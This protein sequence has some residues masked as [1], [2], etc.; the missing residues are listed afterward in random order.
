MVA[1]NSPTMP[2]FPDSEARTAVARKLL[3]I[4]LLLTVV[5]Y[6]GTLRYE[7]V[8]DDDPQIVH[9][10]LLR[11]W[12]SVPRFFTQHLWAQVAPEGKGNFYRPLFLLWFLLN[13]KLFHLQPLGWHVTTVA[14]HVLVTFLVY[15]LARRVLA[16]DLAG[17]VAA[18]LFGL[19][20]THI[21]TVAWISGVSDSLLAA[22]FLGSL[23]CWLNFREQDA[24]S[25]RSAWLA[26]SLLLGAVALLCKETAAVLPGV[27]AAGEFWLIS[28]QRPLADR[29]RL[30]V[31]TALPFA[32][33]DAWY[34]AVRKVVLTGVA[35]SITPLPLRTVLLTWPSLLWFYCRH[36]AWPLGLAAFYETPY[37]SSPGLRSFW[38][39]LLAVLAVVVGL[40]LASWKARS[41]VVAFCC[42]F[43]LLPLLPV[44][45]ITAFQYAEIAH[46]RYLYLPSI[47]LAMLLAYVVVRL[48]AGSGELLGMPAAAAAATLVLAGVLAAATATQNVQWANTLLL[49]ARAVAI[50]PNNVHAI[51][52]LAMEFLRR[53]DYE[54]AAPLL[55]RITRLVPGDWSTRFLLGH[56]LYRLHRLPAAEQALLDAIAL[57]PDNATQYYFLGLTR[58]ELQRPTEAEPP[59]RRALQ[60]L[61]AGRGFHEALAAVLL[62]R[63]DRD[64]AR[65]ELQIEV[66]NDPQNQSAQKQLADLQP[67]P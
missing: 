32:A 14:M 26:A 17:A 38:L 20:P 30:A 31:A 6:V 47:G 64:G 61:P 33:L 35:F 50:A 5:A 9:N 43:M 3:W 57:H 12:H 18:L 37:I 49:Y 19:H 13:Y 41:G 27:I 10:F 42:C 8:F 65:A 39:P 22:P 21:E 53:G 2:P 23:L 29:L 46:D 24:G 15:R 67:R 44:L 62:A 51:E 55:E 66:R 34:L 28:G 36:L 54:S 40:W 52:P 45:D 7:F 58:L 59:L 60:L 25:R 4:A 56:A 48:R 11:N 63:G 16:D 1:A